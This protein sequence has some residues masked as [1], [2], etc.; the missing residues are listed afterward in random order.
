M[1][2]KYTTDEIG[3]GDHSLD[4]AMMGSL[5]SIVGAG[6][7]SDA[8][9]LTTYTDTDTNTQLTDA[10]IAAMGY[11]KTYTDTNT[12][13]S[14]AQVGEM[15]YIKTYT[16]TN[17]TYNFAGSTF[18]SRNSGNPIAIDSATSNM[19]GYTNEST[20]AGYSD[21]GLFVA[22]YSTSWVSQIFSNF[23]TGELSTRGKNSGTWQAWRTVHDSG[24][25]TVD[26]VSKGVTA[27][28]WSNHADAGYL[29]SYNDTNTWRGIHDSPV[30]GATT[31]SISSNW[32]FDNVKTA[33]PA[34][35]LFTDTNT[36]YD[37]SD[38]L[39]TSGKAADSNLLDG[40][41]LHT[42][43]NNGAN[44]VVRTNVH[45]YA[46]FGWINTTSGVA[47]G[48][49]TRI[50]C[51]QDSYLR[52]YT[53]ASL[54]PYILNQ[55]S[56]KNSHTHDYV[57]YVNTD[58]IGASLFYDLNDSNYFLDLNATSRLNRLQTVSTGVNKNSSQTTKDGLSLYGAYVGGEA[59]YGMMFTGTAGSGTH[60]GVT[61]DWAT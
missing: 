50:Y 58:Q 45:G 32:A 9:Y 21:G 13:L 56:T 25:F 29:T 54:A 28:G 61:S 48:T 38:Y 43:R 7:H 5:A 59:T 17:T 36:T 24:H 46:D 10:Q 30:D 16:D 3:I 12:Q 42:G 49:P 31:I 35:A 34:G 52:Y 19:T 57:P 1:G 47:A 2:K 39:T 44:K 22:A 51:S 27:Y 11:I 4:S 41:D 55:G 14:D 15:G 26:E 8:G 18:T 40:L 60:G 23:R 6:L 33:V 20:A 53:P 37:L